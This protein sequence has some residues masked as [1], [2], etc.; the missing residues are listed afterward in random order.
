[1]VRAT[2]CAQRNVPVALTSR[3]RRKSAAPRVEGRH[4]RDDAGRADEGVDAAVGLG[5]G[6]GGRRGADG[7]FGRHVHFGQGDG[8]VRMGLAQ[9]LQGGGRGCGGRVDVPETEG[10]AAVLE[11][12]VGDGCGEG[13]G[14][15]GDDGGAGAREARGG[16]VGRGELGVGSRG[17]CLAW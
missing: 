2:A 12:G 4:A 11:E 8:G 6:E 5:G 16:R 14:A 7:V 10:G 15:A 9:G 13:A 3:V 1:M 17:W